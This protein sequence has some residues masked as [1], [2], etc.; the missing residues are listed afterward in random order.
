MKSRGRRHF[1]ALLLATSV[2]ALAGC[3]D[4]AVTPPSLADFYPELPPATGAA[5]QVFVGQI[6]QA[7]AGELVTG[8][9]QTGM[10]GDY[11]LRNDKASFVVSAPTRV[12]GVVPQGGNIVDAAL[13]D[14]MTQLTQDHFGEMS[15]FYVLGR[16]CE[17]DQM[18]VVRDGAGGGVAALRAIGHAAAN[19]FISIKGI[20]VFPVDG[21]VDPDIEDNV[22][23][24]TTYVLAPG[25][26]HVEVHYSLFNPTESNISGPMGTLNDTG[27]EVEAWGNKLGFKR[28][29]I[30]DIGSLGEPAPV[31]YVAYQGP[32]SAYGIIPRH[33]VP[34][35]NVA[36]LIAGVSLVLLGSDSVF[37]L[38][39]RDNYFLR[40]AAGDGQRQRFD[41]AVGRDGEDIDVVYR[42]A[43]GEALT[44]IGGTVTWSAGGGATG[45]R[46]GVY[47]DLDG[48]GAIDDTDVI[49]SYMDVAADGSYAGQVPAGNL[50]VRAEV[51]D[52]GRSPQAPA[53]AAV[54]LTVPS[55]VRVDYQIVDDL[56]GGSIPGRLLVVGQH[57]AL[58]DTRVFE[59]YDRLPGVVQS[60][61]AIRGTTTDVGDGADPALLLPAGGIYKIYASRG[62]EWSTDAVPFTA[63]ADGNLTF[64]L[65]QV[66]PATGY[67]ST[68]WHVHQI[69]SPDS[70]VGSLDRVRTALS[71]GVEMFSVN[72]HDYVTDLQ[73]IV[74]DLGLDAAL[75][76]I[77]GIEVTPF[78]YGHFNAWPMEPDA[79]SP[80]RGAVDWGRGMA[81]YAMIPDEIFAA[82]RARGAQLIQVNHPRSGSSLGE[83]QSYFDRAEV[84]YD[85]DNRTIFGDFQ[86]ATV[87]NGELRLPNTSLW[88]GAFN[89]LE[90]WN[91]FGHEDSDADGRR[92]NTSLDRVLRD[93]FNMLSMGLPITPA[94]NSDTHTQTADPMGMPRTYVRVADDSGAALASG[95][96]VDQVLATLAG[97]GPSPRDVV[98][99]DGPMIEVTVAG[100][101]ALG[102]TVSGSPSVTFE[103]TITAPEWADL[104]TLE[105]FANSTPTVPAPD[106]SALAPLKCYT[107]RALA[108]LPATDPCRLATLAAE[109]MTVTVNN[110]SGPGNH[111]QRRAVVS[112]TMDAADVTTRAGATGTD[113][114]FVFRVSGDRAIFPIMTQ[115]A[116]DDTTLPLLVAGTPA[117]VDAAL[118]GR[119]VQAIAF[120]APVL[121]DFDG[122]GYRAPFAPQ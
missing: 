68:E 100:Q 119:G 1:T 78:A 98:V 60:V 2:G 66:A 104:D 26:S 20:G 21:A 6:A 51:K 44:A 108:S 9:A 64:H 94:G 30:S 107:T 53:G 32:G 29:S 4:D 65:R 76:I 40:L 82:M 103:V 13:R 106:V 57:P 122:G 17:H 10:I 97:T 110:V 73:P 34:T 38:L 63:T 95:A 52:V 88:S 8:P 11:F 92:E 111:R 31:E 96:A 7:N 93:W 91:G 16:T 43:K 117:E 70:P 25:A 33:D 118:R 80:N 12:I 81:G 47:E 15:L 61:H 36:V 23:C 55:P 87:P 84:V 101:P 90:V 99:T 41:F 69:G 112:I 59:T 71:S 49:V 24:A 75:R 3:G 37:D 74:T 115:G 86:N 109:A 102:R 35:D 77:P 79:L 62:T 89:M 46:V 67:L 27:G 50:L 5:Q 39:N 18:E 114:W 72:D 116:I 45:A 28:V 42:S 105:V 113:A 56:T 83:F 120:T 121:V 58:P 48:N 85:Y 14:G 54:A 19:D 22:V